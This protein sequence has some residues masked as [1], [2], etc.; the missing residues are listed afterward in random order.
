[1]CNT[2]NTFLT[3]KYNPLFYTLSFLWQLVKVFD[4]DLNIFE[5]DG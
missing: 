5:L 4:S 2:L 3:E 1:M